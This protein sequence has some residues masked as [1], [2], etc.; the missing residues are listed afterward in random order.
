M[1]VDANPV[2][3]RAL[4]ESREKQGDALDTARGK[5]GGD[6]ACR[7]MPA[8]RQKHMR[9]KEGQ[10]REE[11]QKHWLRTIPKGSSES[12]SGPRQ[13]KGILPPETQRQTATAE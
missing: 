5:R 1:G 12:V 6:K 2:G 10:L 8:P 9:R 3:R 4:A 7:G 13:P 11:Q